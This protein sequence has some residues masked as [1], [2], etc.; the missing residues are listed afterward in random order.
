MID[1]NRCI[2]LI[3]EYSRNVPYLIVAIDGRCG[4]GKTT[5]AKMLK[6]HYNCNVVPMD[7]F[8]LR[9]EQRTIERL[10]AAGENIDHERFLK[11]VL[12][13]LTE[14]KQFSYCPFN[15]STMQ[16]GEPI[17][18]TT[19][20]INI[21]EGSYCCNNAL[22]QHYH[23]RIFLTVDKEEQLRRITQR[24]GAE[25]AEIYQTKWIPLE[26]RYFAAFDIEKRC[27]YRFST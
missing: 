7:H 15:C 2:S 22:W 20:R 25:K 4:S 6:E 3:D 16:L 23:L 27:D 17:S 8:F 10:S 12:L 26:E 14:G 21:I 24:D 5:L 19:D 1:I 9:P 18:V 13:P 11:E